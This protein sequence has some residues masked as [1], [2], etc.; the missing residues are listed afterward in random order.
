MAGINTENN[1]IEAAKEME[2]AEAEAL[3]DGAPQYVHYFR[4]PFEWEGR[5]HTKLEF[6]FE[7]LTGGD[8]LAIENEL[9]MKGI[10]VI[11][12]T[13]SSPFLIRMASRAC[14]LGVDAFEAMTIRDYNQIR[15]KARNFLLSSEL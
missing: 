8:A 14:G 2:A 13:F 6:D 15:S 11:T 1:E 9:A 7:K 4:K 10:Q 5:E 3:K 12:P